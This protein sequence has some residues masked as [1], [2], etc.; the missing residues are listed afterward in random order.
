MN[1][2]LQYENISQQEALMLLSSDHFIIHLLPNKILN[3]EQFLLLAFK[4]DQH[5]YIFVQIIERLQKN[6][7]NNMKEKE[8]LN[9]LV[10]NKELMLNIINQDSETIFYVSERLKNDKDIALLA[11]K[12]D[13]NNLKYLTNLKDNYEIVLEAVKQ[14]G[15]ALVYAS[16]R[17]KNN[18]VIALTAIN[19][20]C[21][22][23]KFLSKQLS[24]DRILASL[25]IKENGLL[26]QYL[27]T[28]LSKNKELNLLAVEENY[29][30][31]SLIN[32]SLINDKC[33]ALKALK[34]NEH[35]WY[36]IGEE[37]KEEIGMND[38]IEY[39]EKYLLSKKFNQYLITKSEKKQKIKI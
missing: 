23:Y 20:N 30:A 34:N 7:S 9:N 37:L 6:E 15:E 22:S 33:I 29:L 2:K 39:L 19:N 26:I 21:N 25:C 35:A 1:K 8:L 24:N 18:R 28:K 11:V 38:P 31:M 4:N 16:K 10:N 36:Y 12:K 17:L 27:P 5:A 3:D 14:S 13:G 32:T